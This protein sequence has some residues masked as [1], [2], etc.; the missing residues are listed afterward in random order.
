MSVDDRGSRPR[1][2]P[3]EQWIV[4]TI[5][6]LEDWLA[7]SAATM[8]S[9]LTGGGAIEEVERIL[10]SA[11]S[12]RSAAFV[13]SATIGMRAALLAAGAGPGTEVII[14][15]L[16]WPSSLAAVRSVGA[17]PVVV[18][19]DR[20]TLTVSPAAVVAAVGPA[21]RAVVA[22]H[23]H[24][25]AA[26]VPALRRVLE[27]SVMVI[28]DAAQAIG[29][30]VADVPVGA[31]GDLAVLSFGPGKRLDAGEGGMVVARDPD[32]LRAVIAASAHPMRQLLAGADP[33]EPAALAVRPT[34]VSAIML[35]AALQEWDP[36][37]DRARYAG[38]VRTLSRRPAVR[39]IGSALGAS[40]S[41]VVPVIADR[42]ALRGFEWTHSG[43]FDITATGATASRF[44][45]KL[46]SG[47]SQ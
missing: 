14:P 18:G 9:A 24:G 27:P 42:E 17:T 7:Q 47:R 37:A 4:R 13:A 28:E 1:S 5:A 20:A 29:G 3:D 32:L 40:A 34:A 31:L 15:A 8:T 45:V 2:H 35:R 41:P 22:C 44:P 12:G 23:L 36:A 21:T 30:T 16:D 46:V 25:V 10:G 33:I 26:D 38:L 39:V 19:V 11:H 43:M 6:A